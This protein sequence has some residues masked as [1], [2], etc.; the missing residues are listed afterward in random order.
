[1][2]KLW[3]AYFLVLGLLSIKF[4]PLQVYE[5]FSKK[6][7]SLNS[8]LLSRKKASVSFFEISLKKVVLID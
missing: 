7:H 5:I 1:M 3:H 6:Q 4:E 8:K 2:L